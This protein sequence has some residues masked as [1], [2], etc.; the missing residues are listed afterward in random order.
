VPPWKLTNLAVL[1]APLAVLLAHS[2]AAAQSKPKHT[3]TR[4]QGAAPAAALSE[5]ARPGAPKQAAAASAERPQLDAD[6][7]LSLEALRS[8]VRADQ[9]QILID[10]I[11]DT[12][13]RNA[14]EK[15]SLY[16]RLGELYA[17]QH[18]FFRLKSQE[19]ELAGARAEATRAADQAQ[20]KLARAVATYKALADNPAFRNYPRLDQ[21][22]FYYGFMLKS[23]RHHDRARAIFDRL[24]KDHPSSKHVPEAHLVFADYFFE[25]GELPN[26]A[27]RYRMVLKFPQSPAYWYATYQT[28]W[29]SLKQGQA[30]EALERFYQV[31]QA[32]RREPKQEVL[33]RAAKKDYVR[34][35]AEIGRAELAYNAF[36]R[37][38]DASALQMLEQLADHY[39]VQGKS[40]KAIVTYQDLMKRA[41]KHAHVCLWQYNVAQATLSLP[42][43]TNADRV[44]EIENLVRVHAALA[45]GKAL[46]KA[47]ADECRDNAAAMSGD[48]ARAFHAEFARTQDPATL[49][50]ADRLY[51]I[52]LDAFPAAPDHP[53]TQYFHAELLWARAFAEQQP[54]LATELWERA[55][56]AFT[57]VVVAGKVDAATRKE[58]AYAAVL[59]WKNALD[60][61]PRPKAQAGPLPQV[62]AAAA[63]RAG[64]PADEAVPRPRPI[65]EREQKMIA[66]FDLYL[67]Y[68]RGPDDDERIGIKF[69]KANLYRRHDHHDRAI[70]LLRELLEQHRTHETAEYAAQ[71]LLDSYN[72]LRRHDEMLALAARLAADA[73]FVKDKPEL[74]KV[75][76]DL[77]YQSMEKRAHALGEAAQAAGDFG[78]WVACGEAYMTIYNSDP[79][80]AENDRVL[81]NAMLCFHRG[82]S[83]GLAI[84]AFDLLER[85][86]PS[87]THLARA[88]ALVGKAYGDTAFYDKAAAVLE[89]YARKYAGE[90]D[91]PKVMSEV[92]FF[93][94]GLGDD[95]R[96]IENTRFFVDAFGARHPAEAADAMFSLAAVYEK[97][98][99]T[100]GL[101]RHLRAYLTRFGETGGAERRV[102]AHAK[103]G[104]AL[105][106][107]SCPVKL[108]DGACVKVARERAIGRRDARLAA[109]QKQ[110]GD[111]TRTKLTA[112]P[113]DARRVAEAMAAFAAAAAAWGQAGGKPGAKSGGDALAARHY[114]AQAKL[115]EAD[116]EYE[117]FLAI[118]MPANLDFHRADPARSARSLQRFDAWLARRKQTAEAAIQKYEAARQAT[119]NATSIAAV[120]RLAQIQHNQADAL[121][122]TEIP[123]PVRTG[124]FAEDKIEAFCDRMAEVG[125]PLEE[126]AIRGYQVCLEQGRRLGWFGD[127]SKLCERELGQLRPIEHPP[128]SELRAA[129]TRAAA[130]VAVEPPIR[131]LE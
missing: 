106:A 45:G 112:V 7:A 1:L 104:L 81:Y 120:A 58:A 31:A 61:D 124:A 49:A 123:L 28:G 125:E 57:R 77:H 127:W 64:G 126:A 26:A 39:L 71:L 129:P 105:W 108:V 22:L 40:G 8:T 87:S 14:D 54:R 85:Y 10:L 47:D 67:T 9:E 15:A 82:K 46:P 122:T 30:Q 91:A 90:A 96:A 5:R 94:K 43:A 100:G 79:E 102:I 65:P 75:I 76:T 84:L 69:L 113:R 42:G 99:D 34:A 18:R 29:I 36:A 72:R 66:A 121:F 56:E 83:I 116:R 44:T 24:L 70:P 101:V 107:A 50:H 86:Y 119:D 115:A 51:R 98:G 55:A 33:H 63:A 89:R 32:T 68:V 4:K 109:E 103:I 62:A 17:M 25:R 114:Y 97:R 118:A 60:V 59:G 74:R 35:Y 37:V 6:T 130:I 13:D 12:P 95:A 80:R 3:Y 110:C 52:Y 88:L 78:K 38:D 93:N 53:Q 41:P 27:E 73:A 21:A 117:A 48:H 11:D 111:A 16:F 19:R 131:R 2:A 20:H 23:A 128:A 92:V